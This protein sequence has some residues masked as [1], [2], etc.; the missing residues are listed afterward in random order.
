MRSILEGVGQLPFCSRLLNSKRISGK[1]E[2]KYLIFAPND[3]FLYS[4]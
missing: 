1:L 2:A 4:K 3:A